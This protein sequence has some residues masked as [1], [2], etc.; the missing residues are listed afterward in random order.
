MLLYNSPISGNCYKVRLLL[1]HRDIPYERREL[2]VVDRSNRAEVLPNLSSLPDHAA[3]TPASARRCCTT[4]RA[5][6]SAS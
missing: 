5:V 6:A 2:D 1:A 4:A 3:S